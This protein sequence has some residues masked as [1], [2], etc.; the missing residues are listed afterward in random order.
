MKLTSLS[1]G[2]AII[3]VFVGLVVGGCAENEMESAQLPNTYETKSELIERINTSL[4]ETQLPKSGTIDPR[5]LNNF[6]DDFGEYFEEML[7]YTQ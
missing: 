2:K 3:G 4:S 6:M 5:N 7:L 1:F